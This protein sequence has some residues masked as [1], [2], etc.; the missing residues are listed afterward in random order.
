VFLLNEAMR[1]VLASMLLCGLFAAALPSSVAQARRTRP[2]GTADNTRQP[3]AP[4][5]PT[6][7]VVPRLPAASPAG[8]ATRPTPVIV[9]PSR[10]QTATP[11]TTPTPQATPTPAQTPRP[12]PTAQDSTGDA[13]IEDDEVVRVTSNLVVVPVSVTDANGEAVQGLKLADFK[14]EEEGRGQELSAVGDADQVPLDIALVFDLSSSVTKNFEFEKQAAAG[15]LKQVLK[16][17]DRAA[18]FSIAEKPALLQPLASADV[19][20][21]K[22]ATLRAAQVSTGTAFYDTV[23]AAARYLAANAPERNRRVILVISDGEDNFSDEVRDATVAA[24]NRTDDK[25]DARTRVARIGERTRGLHQQAL[26]KLLRDV[27]GADAV[28]YSINP[29]GPGLRLNV[30]SQRAQEGMQQLATTTGG[31]SFV[32]PRI[33]NLEQVF[34]QIAA[35]L[36]AQYLLQYLSNT[37][38]QPGKFLRIKVTTPARP[39]LRVRSRQGYYKKG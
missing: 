2:R 13:D 17:I 12:Q 11:Q 10:Q 15:F 8:A 29:S 26:R 7:I 21:A 27:Q 22:V 18:I 19:A 14:L 31:S 24:Y 9:V 39:E 23:R 5:T 20:S 34:R 16:P 37:D 35:E 3:A 28:F 38:A 30:I 25:E 33:E 4:A 32:P 6:P 36:R 1:K